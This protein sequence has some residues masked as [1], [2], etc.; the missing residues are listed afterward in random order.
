ML[1][2]KSTEQGGILNFGWDLIIDKTLDIAADDLS[3]S[4]FGSVGVWEYKDSNL[5]Q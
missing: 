1:T 2:I 3:L 4:G 5:S